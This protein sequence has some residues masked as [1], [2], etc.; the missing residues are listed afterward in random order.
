M[1]SSFQFTNPVLTDLEIHLNEGFNE[2]D[3]EQVQIQMDISVQVSPKENRNEA[4]VSLTVEIGEQ[5]NNVP[6]WIKATERAD[7]LWDEDVSNVMRERLLSQNAPSLLL[8]Y[9]RPIVAQIT[10]AS[11]Y[12]A[13]NIPFINFTKSN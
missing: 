5:G 3:N 2:E 6:F 7:F 10:N 13:Y 11:P 12:G 9:L 4:I 8:G 1:E